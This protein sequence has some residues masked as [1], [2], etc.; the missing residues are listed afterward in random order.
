TP[1]RAFALERLLGTL[2]GGAR[3]TAPELMAT[4]DRTPIAWRR[5]T[6]ILL[7][8]EALSVAV[9]LAPASI[10]IVKWPASGPIR[11]ALLSPAWQ[12]LAWSVGAMAVALAVIA[13]ARAARQASPTRVFGP[14]VVL[15]LWLVPYLSWLPD[16][17]PPFRLV[18]GPSRL[19]M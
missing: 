1:A 11:L 7:G 15:W 10:H 5:A 6:V 16:L 14:L 18:R 19:G 4:A 3:K 12:L 2:H 8:A 17:L 9:W 13:G